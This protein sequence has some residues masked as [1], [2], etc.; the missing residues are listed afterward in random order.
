MRFSVIKKLFPDMHIEPTKGNKKEAE[1]YINK[2]G[3]HE[4]KGETI[5]CKTSYGE[6]KGFQGKRSDLEAIGEML[7]QEMTPDEILAQDF[8]YYRYQKEIRSAYFDRRRRKTPDEREVT[9][10]WHVGESGS[11]KSHVQ[12]DLKEKYGRENVYLMTDYDGGGLDR[13]N[14][15]SVLFMDEFRGQI[16]YNQLLTMLDG[17]PSQQHARYAN[18]YGL[19]DEVHITSVL[20]PERVYSKMVEEN[21]DLDTIKQLMRR[22]DFIVYHEKVSGEYKSFTRSMERYV[23]YGGLGPETHE[24]R[25]A[26]I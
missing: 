17:Y 24:C 23:Y 13:Y 10:Y 7:E 9:V 4:E 11:G 21:R 5:V 18:I 2:I 3:K 20:P 1:D 25:P 26:G 12:I 8:R 19:W 16:K 22:I 6:I 14:G 15:E